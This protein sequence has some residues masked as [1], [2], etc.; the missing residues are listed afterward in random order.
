MRVLVIGRTGQLARALMAAQSPLASLQAVGRPELDLETQPDW[1]ALL[2]RLHPDVVVNAAAYTLVDQAEREP[3]RASLLNAVEPGRLALACAEADTALIHVSTDYVFDGRKG[4]PYVETDLTGPLN[5]YGRSKLAGETG[6]AAAGGRHLI[7]RTSWVF[8]PW[9][10]NFVRTILR[11]A[12][13]GRPLRVVEDQFGCPTYAPDLA[14]LVLQLAARLHAGAIEGGLYHAAGE[15]SCS[16]RDLAAAVLDECRVLGGPRGQVQGIPGSEYPTP[17]ARPADSRL[18]C[19][20]LRRMHGLQAP[21][22]RVGVRACIEQL[23]QTGYAEV[24]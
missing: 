10:R 19:G 17:A 12:A 9:G 11:L 20:K 14:A 21:H 13:E 7:L 16:W 3:E 18:D 24:K 15:G 1:A 23:A 4:A 2:E 22:W 8:A 5:A 6:V